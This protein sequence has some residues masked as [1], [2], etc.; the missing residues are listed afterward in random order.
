MRSIFVRRIPPPDAEVW[1]GRRLLAL[2]DALAWPALWIYVVLHVQVPTGAL[3]QVVV[4]AAVLVAVLRSIKAVSRNERY[5]FSTWRWG[6][7][8]FAVFLCG[9]ALK[10]AGGVF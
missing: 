2:L 6:R 8:V 9:I 10:M 3:G 4:G 5:Q 7:F 1:A